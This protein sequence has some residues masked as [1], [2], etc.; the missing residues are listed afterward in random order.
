M[1]SSLRFFFVAAFAFLAMGA[2]CNLMWHALVNY[3]LDSNNSFSRQNLPYELA[4]ADYHLSIG[5]I[6]LSINEYKAI[7]ETGQQATQNV[8]KF[9]LNQI[10]LNQQSFSGRLSFIA[11]SLLWNAYPRLYGLGG[12][13]VLIWGGLLVSRI[14][15]KSS[16]AMLP[17][18]NSTNLDGID[19]LSNL[20]IERMHEIQWKTRELAHAINKLITEQLEIPTI[21]L[22]DDGKNV[23][24]DRIIETAWAVTSGNSNLSLAELMRSLRFWINAPRYIVSGSLFEIEESIELRLF[25]QRGDN[26]KLEKTW[27]VSLPIDKKGSAVSILVDDIA[28]ALFHY[29]SED[30]STKNWRALQAATKGILYFD[31]YFAN[32]QVTWLDAAQKSLESALLIDPDY[33]VARYNLG[34]VFMAVGQFD[35]ARTVLKPITL[36]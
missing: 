24:I 17:I 6:E 10:L 33:V 28:F 2:I 12:L 13:F 18:V 31:L 1:K 34:L 21:G 8:A 15:K 29:F 9:R 35:L 27:Q 32:R 26:G 19:K 30:V 16:F 22:A 23:N 7:A 14:N 20:A 11:A 5:E 4:L 25:L 36:K 3:V